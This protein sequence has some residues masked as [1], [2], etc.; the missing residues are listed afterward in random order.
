MKLPLLIGAAAAALAMVA[1]AHAATFLV[2][3]GGT[4]TFDNSQTTAPGDK[5]VTFNGSAPA[6]TAVTLNGAAIV[7]GNVGGQYAQ[8]F[9]SD[10]SP[11]LSVFGGTSATI[12]DTTGIGYNGLSLYLGSIDTYNAIDI[13]STTGALIASFGGSSFLGGPSG[14]QTLPAT[15]RLISFTRDANDPLFGGV[16]IRSS[17]NSAEVDNVRFLSPA[18]V[19]EPATWAMMLFGFG[20]LGIA[21]RRRNRASPTRLAFSA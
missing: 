8:P 12:A 1:P 14:D 18:A 7:S 9:G 10:G 11:Y 20:F 4:V 21:L 19:P 15:N 3:N 13:L 16:T 2:T 6:G 17:Q 5:V